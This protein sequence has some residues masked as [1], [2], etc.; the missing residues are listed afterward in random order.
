MKRFK[1]LSI[2]ALAVTVFWGLSFVA[3]RIGLQ[4]F[5]PAGLVGLRMGM[6]AIVLLVIAR[7]MGRIALPAKDLLPTLA[8]GLILAG[9]LWIQSVGLLKTS[10]THT[11]WIIG[12]APITIAV[13]AWWF[14]RQPI[15][16]SAWGGIALGTAGV[17]LICL[18]RG[19]DFSDATMGDILQVT[20]CVTWAAYTIVAVGPVQR[21]GSLRI[22]LWAIIVA[23]LAMSPML[24]G[25][26][27]AD[28]PVTGSV[29]LSV[30]FLGVVCSG[31]AF[32][33]WSAAVRD[34]GSAAA[35]AYLYLEPFVTWL[36]AAVVLDESLK[37][38]GF[39]GGALVLVGVW[40]VSRSKTAIGSTESVARRST[41]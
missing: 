39:A 18:S 40:V 20:S 14:L 37:P 11:G 38:V 36:A 2:K 33:V 17:A 31:L 8:L 5:T 41:E 3:T 35:G 4:A 22:T 15:G 23:A 25:G 27:R 9:H 21:H 7:K 32:W 16:A 10:A 26:V 24:F 19:L 28:G 29:V 1:R 12:F 6:A 34:I 30:V 13:G